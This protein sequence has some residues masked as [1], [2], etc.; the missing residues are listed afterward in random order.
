ME[1]VGVL[2]KQVG[3]MEPELI[4]TGGGTPQIQF[5]TP[6]G[7]ATQDRKMPLRSDPERGIT[8]R[9]FSEMMDA[10]TEAR[11]AAS[12]IAE[13]EGGRRT[14]D[15][16]EDMTPREFDQHMRR[17]DLDIGV[18]KPRVEA[19]E[20][21]TCQEKYGVEAAKRAQRGQEATAYRRGGLGGA[22]GRALGAG[23]AGAYGGLQ[24][25]LALN[26]AGAAGQDLP[27]SLGG[28][29]L[30]GIS[31]YQTT[32]PTARDIGGGVGSRVAVRGGPALDAY[33][34][35]RDAR[36]TTRMS[37]E[38][39]RFL[40][41]M[42]FDPNLNFNQRPAEPT[43]PTYPGQIPFAPTPVPQSQVR[44][45]GIEADERGRANER[46]R[47]QGLSPLRP[48]MAP[49]PNAPAPS[50]PPVAVAQPVAQPVA[51]STSIEPPTKPAPPGQGT[52]TALME[53]GKKEQEEA[54]EKEEER[55]KNNQ[56][57]ALDILARQAQQGS[58]QGGF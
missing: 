16:M 37:R 20:P 5:R 42:G 39:S 35:A 27:S 23:A 47:L 10:R 28:A 6:I 32:A 3:G 33:R 19:A 54:A 13:L 1:Q 31:S 41:D 50:A 2:R 49:L 4:Q 51:E 24:A 52:L 45:V 17:T 9:D 14:I 36:A 30:Q 57:N 11:A 44:Y 12:K 29:T 46:L 8:S 48:M 7:R 25:L 55:V 15:E 26:R 58:V 40:G 18:L 56:E 43:V 34:A 53:Q 21:R 22:T 38:G